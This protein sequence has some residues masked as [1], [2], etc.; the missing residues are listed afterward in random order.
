M[1]RYVFN[2]D[3]NGLLHKEVGKQ[4]YVTQLA[5]EV[6]MLRAISSPQEP[7]RFSSLPGGGSLPSKKN[8][9]DGVKHSQDVTA[10]LSE[11]DF[12]TSESFFMLSFF[13]LC[14]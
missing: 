1:E 14:H 3:E 11:S 6:L 13:S 4:M 8:I 5:P 9:S 2:V 12:R 10:T 7:H